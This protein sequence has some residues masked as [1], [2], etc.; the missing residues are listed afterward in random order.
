[1]KI[2]ITGATGF[3]GQKLTNKFIQEGH[4]VHAL[5]RNPKKAASLLDG[6]HLIQWSDIASTFETDQSF[7]D[8][9][10]NLVGENIAQ[11]RWNEERK[12]A[13]YDSRVLATRNLFKSLKEVQIHTVIQASAIG[14]YG[15]RAAEKLD[16]ESSLADD[17]LGR[18]CQDWEQAAKEQA[19]TYQRLCVFRL[20]VV[21]GAEGALAK[22]LPAFKLGVGGRLGS[23]TQFMSWVHIDD[24]IAA[25]SNAT[26]D[27]NFAG[28][29]NLTAPH[30]VS[31][32]EFT[33]TLGK[34]LGRPTIF[35]APA[36]MLQLILGEM[37]QLL[38]KGQR[39]YPKRLEQQGMSFQFKNLESALKDLV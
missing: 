35:P 32:L 25:I 30:P 27:S 7:F 19:H 29:Y 36:G 2:L 16:E 39:V 37:S 20:G 23:G 10:I 28:V 17:F 11:K 14:I 33:K 9:V 34:A 31:N 4:E 12:Q 22:M 24:V 13:L 8:V 21:L 26:E 18:L 3:I 15:S 1:M 6:A 38:L 5:V